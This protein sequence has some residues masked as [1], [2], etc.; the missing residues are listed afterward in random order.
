M[1]LIHQE[2]PEVDMIDVL[3]LYAGEPIVTTGLDGYTEIFDDDGC[4]IL[5]DD[6]A[7]SM[8]KHQS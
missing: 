7:I 3:D 8:L 5:D 6:D 2:D 1:L 4:D